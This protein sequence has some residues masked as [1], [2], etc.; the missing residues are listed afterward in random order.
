MDYQKQF[1]LALLGYAVQRG[2]P[3]QRLCELSGID[4]TALQK[5]TK[6]VIGPGQL[7]SLWK[8]AC[9]LTNDHLFG[10]HFGE[11]MQLAALGVIGQIVQTSN[12]V[13]EALTN[14]G[15]L[16]PL[17]TDLFDMKVHRA[18]QSF[19]IHFLYRKEKANAFPFTFRCMADYL[20]VFVVHEL[21]GLLLERIE[22]K[23]VHLPYTITDTWEYARVLRCSTRTTTGELSMEFANKYLQEPVLSANYELQ[24]LLL[25]KVNG[26]MKGNGNDSRLRIR[27]FNYLLTNSYL[28]ASS[29]E[30]VAANFNIST[31]SLQR[32]LKEEGITYLQIVEEVRK[33]LAI[34]YLT[35]E[36]Y[37]VKDI[38]Y[39]LGY[40]E[41]SAFLRAFKRW[42]N[43]T[44]SEYQRARKKK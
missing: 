27:I 15:A 1:I 33:T 18:K 44:P 17:I 9:H 26:F 31:R 29:Q 40:N 13:G 25:Q 20:I 39:I 6:T 5:N 36:N 30:A 24:Q 28:Y 32:K 23:A 7:N 14:A 3:A 38:A 35:N 16:T 41:Q 42:T 21:D 34:N 12:T 10:L 22:P 19:T 8:N 11:S 4:L 37:S 43:K 2:V